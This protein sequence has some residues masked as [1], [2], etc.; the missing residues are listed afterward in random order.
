MPSNHILEVGKDHEQLG[1]ELGGE[2]EDKP[3]IKPEALP[4]RYEMEAS[5]VHELDDQS[6]KPDGPVIKKET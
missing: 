2:L 1:G 6:I 5:S 4:L 3:A